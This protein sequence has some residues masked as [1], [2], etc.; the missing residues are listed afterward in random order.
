MAQ[1][2]VEFIENNI[3]QVDLKDL[4][5]HLKD[6]TCF[7]SGIGEHYSL[8]AVSSLYFN[9]TTL[10]DIGTCT[11]ASAIALAYNTKNN[12][13]SYDIQNELGVHSKP[14]NVEFKIGDF[15]LDELTLQSPLIVIDVDP[16]DGNLEAEFHNFFVQKKYNGFVLWDDVHLTGR[17]ER[18]IGIDTW[19]KSLDSVEKYDLTEFGHG[20]GTGLIVYSS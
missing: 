9:N 6:P 12:V 14:N 7:L 8:L 3:H 17:N 20:T 5:S 13:I 2:F 11:G 10:F 4:S 1:D 19:W 16:H 15:R 18:G